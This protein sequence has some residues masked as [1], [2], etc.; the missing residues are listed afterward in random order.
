MYKGGYIYLTPV[1]N[2]TSVYKM[3]HDGANNP[4]FTFVGQS[5]ELSAG[6]VGCGVPTVTTFQGQTGSAIVWLTVSFII[7]LLWVLANIFKDVDAGLRAWHAVPQNGVLKTINL[8]QTNGLNKFQRPVF[9]DGKVYV[10]DS[11]GNLYCMGS[12]VA[13]PLN[14]SSP[15]Q[16][17]NVALGSSGTQI[18]NCTANIAITKILGASVGDS[19]FQFSNSSFPPGA[20]T[21]GSS[22]SF[23][24]TWNLTGVSASSPSKAEQ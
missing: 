17:G 1:G 13:L 5:N 6:R 20:I 21:K 9:G 8:P 14:C 10:T 24:V 3:G 23:P 12:P 16:F 11:Q 7:A 19:H 18:I 15:V 2:T 22:F 4:V